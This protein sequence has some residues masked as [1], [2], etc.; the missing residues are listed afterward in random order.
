MELKNVA[1][2]VLIT[3]VLSAVITKYYFPKLQMQTVEVEKEVI[4][5]NIV[6]VT[7][8]VKDK[9]GNETSETTTVDRSTT[10]NT[11]SK[12]VS[13]AASKDWMISA[14]AQT[15]FKEGLK[16]VYGVQVQRRILGPF[17]VGGTVN[18]DRAVGVSVG[19]EF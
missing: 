5:N 2:L 17:Y 13:I 9:D 11:D 14:S 8:I 10:K 12:V 1:I 6:T 4:K 15:D 3:A 18:T 19:F 16:P 7:K